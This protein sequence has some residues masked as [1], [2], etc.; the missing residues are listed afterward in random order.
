[1]NLILKAIGQ[2]REDKA[3]K[4]STVRTLWVPVINN[5][6]GLGPWGFLETY[7][8]WDADDTIRMVVKA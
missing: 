1:M 2:A 5:Y 6:A 8:P 7:D 4:V 3:A